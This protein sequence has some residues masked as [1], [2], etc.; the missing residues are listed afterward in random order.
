MERISKNF[1]ME[2]MTYSTIGKSM[3]IENKPNKTE[4]ENI[5]KLVINVL[6]PIRDKLNKPIIINSGYRNEKI[7]KLV[8]GVNSSQHKKGQAADIACTLEVKDMILEIIDKHNIPYDQL[9]I[10]R[11]FIHISYNE[12]NNRYQTIYKN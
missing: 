6:Q 1:T 4:K 11:G 3:S 7:N 5:K 2:E 12:E 9:I 10:Y 8:G